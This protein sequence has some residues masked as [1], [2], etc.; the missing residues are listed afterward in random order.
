VALVNLVLS[1]VPLTVILVLTKFRFHPTIW[2]IP[3]SL[4]FET[5]FTLG[6][7]FLVFTLA[8]RFSE[9]REMY[10]VLIN[11]WFFITPIVYPPAIVPAKYRFILWLNPHYYLIQ[12]FRTPIYDGKLPPLPVVLFSAGIAF[13]TFVVGWIFFCRRIEDYAFRS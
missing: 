6:I 12:T 9:I 2:F 3:V 10:L 7:G 11:T 5:A 4:V 13:T 1:I 8:S